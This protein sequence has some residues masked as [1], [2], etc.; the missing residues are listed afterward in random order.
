MTDEI[1]APAINITLDDI[2]EANMLSLHCPI[3]AGPVENYVTEPALQ[4]VVCGQC[5]T[6]Y[7]KICWEQKGGKCAVLGCEHTQYRPF[8]TPPDPV[9]VIRDR[10]LPRDVRPT[11][12][13]VSPATKQ[14]KDEQRR[15]Y[16]EI[17]QRGLWSLFWDWL[18][19]AIKI[20]T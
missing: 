7:H 3:C 6:L 4:P 2:T 16:Q 11:S 15:A 8:G 5:G 12:N 1:E 17:Q 19:R 10:D 9:L 13:G 14:L 20:R 18:L